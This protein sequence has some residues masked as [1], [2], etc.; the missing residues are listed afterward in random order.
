M[1]LTFGKMTMHSFMSFLDESFDFE[2]TE[3]MVLVRGVNNDAPQGE[4]NGSGKSTIGYALM[5]A[6]FG[7][8]YADIRRS[9]NLV[10]RGAE[11]RQ[12]SVRLRFRADDAEYEIERGLLR[13]KNQ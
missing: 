12:M 3:G 7:E 2:G 9:E 13:G 10:S 1:R 4:T 11:D 5:Y 6:L 8:T